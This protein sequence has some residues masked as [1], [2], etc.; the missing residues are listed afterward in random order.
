MPSRGTKWLETSAHFSLKSHDRISKS[1]EISWHLYRSFV[2][3]EAT[4]LV[5]VCLPD[6]VFRQRGNL[7]LYSSTTISKAV[8]WPQTRCSEIFFYNLCDGRMQVL[9]CRGN[10][11]IKDLQR[12][13]WL[14]KDM[15]TEQGISNQRN[16]WTKKAWEWNENKESWLQMK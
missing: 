8:G 15:Q 13:L 6:E 7:A 1:R 12:R 10:P 9:L 5:A 2:E 16:S 4:V 14:L 3:T 11:Y